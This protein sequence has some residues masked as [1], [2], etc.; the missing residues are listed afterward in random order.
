MVPSV[1]VFGTLRPRRSWCD[2]GIV[3]V[4]AVPC[5]RCV[6]S[7]VCNSP[8][9]TTDRPTAYQ[10]Y[11]VMTVLCAQAAGARNYPDPRPG[12]IHTTRQHLAHAARRALPWRWGTGPVTRNPCESCGPGEQLAQG[13]LQARV[14]PADLLRA[15]RA[16]SVSARARAAHAAGAGRPAG[17]RAP[18]AARPRARARRRRARPPPRPPAA[19]ACAAD[20]RRRAR[21]GAAAPAAAAG[22]GASRARAPGRSAGVWLAPGWQACACV[23]GAAT[24]SPG[25]RRRAGG[26]CTAGA[27]LGRRRR[28]TSG[29]SCSS[30]RGRR[31]RRTRRLQGLGVHRST[32]SRTAA[33]RTAPPC[34]GLLCGQPHTRTA[35]TCSPPV[36]P[37]GALSADASA[38]V[39]ASSSC[40][41]CIS[42]VTSRESR[43]AFVEQAAGTAC[44]RARTAEAR[45]RKARARVAAR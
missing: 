22:G 38:R 19:A 2:S 21:R 10:A 23:H 17:G 31:A 41:Q 39:A 1:V 11:M 4:C 34:P 3:M 29:R 30:A 35:R 43:R 12:H 28:L 18:A 9:P 42:G 13:R 20:R 8:P 7:M 33:Y 44:A 24:A 37:P 32:Q 45:T 15:R 36:P 25:A 16:A 6:P 27:P 5:S 14:E 40:R 26:V